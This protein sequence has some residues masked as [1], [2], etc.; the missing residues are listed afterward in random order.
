MTGRLLRIAALALA[1]SAVPALGQQAGRAPGR[2]GS[3]KGGPDKGGTDKG[4]TDRRGGP[5]LIGCPSLANYR[6]LMRGGAQAAAAQ[7]ADPKADHLGCA[8]LPRTEITGIADRVSLGGQS[9]DCAG[10]R[11]TTACHWVEAGTTGR[12]GPAGR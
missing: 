11:G 5:P 9:Y 4:N 6:M 8:T 7:L 10:V 3:D 1:L 12:P 2:A